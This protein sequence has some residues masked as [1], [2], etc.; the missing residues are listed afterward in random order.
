VP[1]GQDPVFPVV[2][3]D[4]RLR[5]YHF[6]NRDLYES[7]ADLSS[8]ANLPLV[9]GIP[10]LDWALAKPARAVRAGWTGLRA[11]FPLW[12][13]GKDSVTLF[14]N[15][16]SQANAGRL[17][18]TLMKHFASALK[19]RVTG[20]TTNEYLLAW[21]R[22]GGE[23]TTPLGQ[24]IPH[25]RVA[26]RKLFKRRLRGRVKG[27]VVHP[28]E[29]AREAIDFYRDLIQFSE[30]APRV[31]EFELL[32]R[33]VGWTAGQSMSLDQSMRLGLGSKEVTADFTE[34]SRFSRTMNMIKPFYTATIAGPRAS[35]RALQRNPVRFMVRG[36]ELTML[37]LMLWW[38]NKDKEWYKTLHPRERFLHWWFEFKNPFTGDQE[39][40]RMPRP[41][42]LGHVF[43][44]LPETLADSWYRTQPELAR[45]YFET[46]WNLINPGVTPVLLDE[47]RDQW[48]NRDDFWE[49]PIVPLGEIVSKKPEQEQYGP[50]T[51]KLAIILGRIFK[52]S[53]R[54][55]DHVIEGLFGGVGE[56]VTA[57]FG[58][59]EPLEG[60]E[61]E[62]ADIPILG[63]F[64]RRGG[65]V[66]TRPYQI[67]RLYDAYNKALM[68]Q[69][70]D[71]IEE[72]SAMRRE[73]LLLGDATALVGHLMYIRSR[74]P[75][76]VERE[77]LA[78]EARDVAVD[79][80]QQLE[81]GEIDR[82][83]V[84]AARK[85]AQRLREDIGKEAEEETPA[86]R[87]RLQEGQPVRLPLPFRPETSV[88]SMHSGAG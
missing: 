53:P 69:A 2:D 86:R 16:Q 72:T 8:P 7:I 44:A 77:Q 20:T 37:T 18:L 56:D 25:T 9:M 32:G 84:R 52:A 11:A 58:R 54:R 1:A 75:G 70:S 39:L 4:G 66:G 50:Y 34:G 38:Y 45:E 59:G 64:F 48:R 30:F 41:F 62:P 10:I 63:R 12:N 31:T 60:R 22:G 43:A 13:F 29:T 17:F 23:I 79:V 67:D 46:A 82:G 14:L 71:E 51:T 33:D 28:I 83:P 78:A 36:L 27:M 21:L 65:L 57:L 47:A 24:D 76:R 61:S 73:R 15:T 42:E 80:V 68:R 3:R 85:R 81:T 6:I 35:L 49:T 87:G 74:T 40:I 19:F 55:I 5:W 88:P 26:M